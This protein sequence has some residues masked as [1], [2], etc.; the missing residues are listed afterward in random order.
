MHWQHYVY[1]DRHNF[2]NDK[3]FYIY[4]VSSAI[5]LLIVNKYSNPN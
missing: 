4:Y 5:K 1:K 2:N 3:E